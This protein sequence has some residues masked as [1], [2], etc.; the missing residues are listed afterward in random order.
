MRPLRAG[1]AVA[2]AVSALSAAAAAQAESVDHGGRWAWADGA[3]LAT[4]SRPMPTKRVDAHQAVA[5]HTTASDHAVKPG[6]VICTS[7]QAELM[8]AAVAPIAAG[9]DRL[10]RS[11]V[12][13]RHGMVATSQPLASEVGLRVLR[14]GGNAVDAAIAIA[15]A[16]SVTTPTMTGL[17][18]DMFLLYFDAKTKTVHALNGS[19]RSPA[20]LTVE[21]VRTAMGVGAD[22]MEYEGTAGVPDPKHPHC[23]TVPGSCAG[24]CDAVETWGSWRMA[25]VLAP[26]IELASE[27]FPVAPV[28]AFMWS[29]AAPT[30][31]KWGSCGAAAELLIKDSNAP[32][33]MRAP[34]AGELFSNPALAN[35]LTEIAD[36]GK[37]AFY[38]GRAAQAI[39]AAVQSAGGLLSMEDMAN[40]SSDFVDAISMEYH[41]V[42]LWEHPPNGQGIAALI[43]ANIL[44]GIDIGKMEH[45]SAEHWHTL[46][47]ALRLAFADARHFVADPGENNQ[48]VPVDALLSHEYGDRRRKLIDP[49]KATVDVRQGSPLASS[50]TVSF[51]VV[52]CHGNAVS[53]VNSV[54]Q[55]F[56][57]GLVAPGTGFVLQNRGANFSLRDGVPNV[58][59][60]GKRPYHTIIPAMITKDGELLASFTNMGGF[61]QPQVSNATVLPRQVGALL[62]WHRQVCNPWDLCCR[63]GTSTSF[64]TSLTS[65]WTRS[66]P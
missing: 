49:H 61:M 3:P 29:E 55:H 63:R 56:G 53:M 51:Q 48:N 18:G 50:D 20:A 19:G 7:L 65:R 5:R 64:A 21:A 54:Y 32:G 8:E 39:V 28:C 23:I 46:I 12:Y 45:G 30:L 15:A 16:L 2:G 27:G 22:G 58:L 52:D 41:G 62:L 35:T 66:L 25:Q 38:R 31:H 37:D 57:V 44:R 26:A 17:G 47:E 4:S 33:G 24:W 43:A 42:E 60:G 11:P 59:A 14:E 34:R 10:R 6:A 9:S 40:H 13:S 36:G 1:A